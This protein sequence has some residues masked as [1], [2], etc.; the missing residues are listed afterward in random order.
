MD[1]RARA[2]GIHAAIGA[3]LMLGYGWGM[4][5]FSALGS[6]SNLYTAA[7]ALFNG[8][9]KFGGIA[10]AI[11]AAICLTGRSVGLLTDAVVS[12]ICGIVM[13]GCAV[14]WITSGGGIDMQ[15]LLILIFGGLFV[16]GARRSL[17]EYRSVQPIAAPPV[18]RAGSVESQPPHPASIR[19]PS[20]SG[21]DAEPPPDGYLAALSKEK[22]EPPTASFE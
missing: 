7:V 15:D 1:E 3:L 11:S 12:G 21:A 2:T 17:S 10:M 19:P 4:G 6:A 22:D 18:A 13:V 9:L 8:M 20:L 16:S 5:G 14:I